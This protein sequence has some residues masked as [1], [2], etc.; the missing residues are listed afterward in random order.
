MKK[1]MA[2]WI[3]LGATVIV[4]GWI[5]WQDYLYRRL[6]GDWRATFQVDPAEKNVAQVNSLK[7]AFYRDGVIVYEIADSCSVGTM[8]LWPNASV[9]SSGNS[10]TKR[11]FNGTFKLLGKRVH[12]VFPARPTEAIRCD[13]FVINGFGIDERTGKSFVKLSL[14]FNFE[15]D[16][17]IVQGYDKG[18]K[19]VLT[20]TPDGFHNP[21]LIAAQRPRGAMFVSTETYVD[22]K[23]LQR[24]GENL[25]ANPD[26]DSVSSGSIPS[27]LR[28]LS[29]ACE[30]Y[31][32]VNNGKYPSSTED[33]AG[34]VP[35]YINRPYCAE[36]IDG[37]V[38]VC[39]FS[40]TGYEIRA[41]SVTG[42]EIFA[43]TTGGV[44]VRRK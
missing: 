19:I 15:G 16:K 36:T 42:N 10:Q 17:L 7:L 37:F 33:L 26:A 3:L 31:A 1:A 32:A 30:A 34:S 39:E 27:E 23:Q 25:L 18:P 4:V 44:P 28:A 2:G 8:D 29:T 41:E 20:K 12:A 38:Y 40:E 24:H 9:I 21:A 13:P 14:R 22:G 11:I 43:I 5:G 35:A 6:S